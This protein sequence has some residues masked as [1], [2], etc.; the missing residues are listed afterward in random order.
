M[1]H[2][3]SMTSL[4]NFPV[5]RQWEARWVWHASAPARHAWV[6]FRGEFDVDTPEGMQLF[7]SADTR[8]RVWINGCLVGDGPPQSQPYHQ[9]Y[10]ERDISALAR[11]GRNCFA[12]S[13]KGSLTSP[14]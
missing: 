4:A 3:S 8:Y 9:Y 5:P 11:R 6:L 13:P 2:S 7:I 14:P 1:K 12:S 10:D